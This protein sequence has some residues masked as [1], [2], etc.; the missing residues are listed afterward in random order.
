M[1]EYLLI[2]PETRVVELYRRGEEGRFT[3]YDFTGQPQISLTSIGCELLATDV[4]DGLG[5]EPLENALV[6]G[7]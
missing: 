3:L 5:F 1:K 2:D 4:F 6:T 7:K